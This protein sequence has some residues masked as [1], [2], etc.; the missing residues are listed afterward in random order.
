MGETTFI[1]SVEVSRVGA[2]PYSPES[3]Q[4]GYLHW[5]CLHTHLKGSLS[6]CHKQSL[7]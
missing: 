1:P 4:V 7:P 5:H 6:G 2:L 3:E